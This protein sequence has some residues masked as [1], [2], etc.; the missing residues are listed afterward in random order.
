MGI[1]MVIESLSPDF[2]ARRYATVPG[3]HFAKSIPGTLSSKIFLC[4]SYIEFQVLPSNLVLQ[5]GD[6]RR[7]EWNSCQH[8]ETLI[9]SYYLYKFNNMYYFYVTNCFDN[10][11][12]F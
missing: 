10:I 9:H 8:L 1:M 7:P 5:K 11:A 6:Y 4:V 12:S 2:T 3:P